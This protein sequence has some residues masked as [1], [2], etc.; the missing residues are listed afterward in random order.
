MFQVLRDGGLEELRL[1][2]TTDLREG[3]VERFSSSRVLSH[4]ALKSTTEGLSGGPMPSA[5]AF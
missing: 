5:V 4:S 2:E 1:E 3:L